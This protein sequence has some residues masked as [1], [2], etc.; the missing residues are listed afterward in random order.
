M[1]YRAAGIVLPSVNLSSLV[2]PV[3]QAATQATQTATQ[4]VKTAQTAVNT[5]TAVL[6]EAQRAGASV[7]SSVRQTAAQLPQTLAEGNAAAKETQEGMAILKV[8]AVVVA[9]VAV[10]G[11]YVYVKRGSR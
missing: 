11:L 2:A 1:S 4:A 5:G 10:G 7:I 3:Q 6:Q 8:A 9:L